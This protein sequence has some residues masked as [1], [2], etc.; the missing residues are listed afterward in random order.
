MAYICHDNAKTT[1]SIDA[2]GWMSRIAGWMN[3][4]RANRAVHLLD[5]RNEH[6]LRDAGLSATDVHS[7]VDYSKVPPEN[8]LSYSMMGA[9]VRFI[10]HFLSGHLNRGPK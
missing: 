9:D 10:D 7:A 3:S 6:L 8:D 5:A 4:F 2:K 1:S